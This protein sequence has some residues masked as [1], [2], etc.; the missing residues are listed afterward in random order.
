MR[1]AYLLTEFPALSETFVVSECELLCREGVEVIPFAFRPTRHEKHFGPLMQRWNAVTER[2]SVAA[3]P[4]LSRVARRHPNRMKRAT[5]ILRTHRSA[6]LRESVASWGGL[7][8]CA[9]AAERISELG[10]THIHAHFARGAATLAWLTSVLADIPF[11]FTAHAFGVYRSSPEALARKVAAA[12]FVRASHTAVGDALRRAS[13]LA[14]DDPKVIEIPTPLDLD[15]IT[16]RP[17]RFRGTPAR[18]LTVARMVPKKGLDLL[19]SIMQHIHRSGIDCELHLLGPGSPGPLKRAP[20]IILHG[21]CSHERVLAELRRSDVFLLPCR[22]TPDGDRDGIPVVLLEAF[23]TGVPAVSTR[24]AGI[25]ELFG[26]GLDTQLTEANDV[27]GLAARVV[28][29][30]TDA[31]AYDDVATRQR[32]VVQQRFGADS[33][34]KLI[35]RFARA[36]A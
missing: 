9:Q 23:A 1:I 31:R 6:D 19:P 12:S 10:V 21:A 30:L 29:L 8:W 2:P 15:R 34:H 28:R 4:A 14:A 16:F 17:P 18:I 26:N 3:L 32:V 7:A 35:K 24:V 13:R 25:P 22:V 36:G 5:E 27:R 20:S 33:V 11:S